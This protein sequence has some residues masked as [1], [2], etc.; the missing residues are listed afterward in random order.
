MVLRFKYQ[1]AEQLNGDG[2]R[3]ITGKCQIMTTNS[4]SNLFIF[5][6]TM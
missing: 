4:D 3:C 6:L 1:N 2:S 5:M